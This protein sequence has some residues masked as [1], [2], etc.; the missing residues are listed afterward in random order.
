MQKPKKAFTLVELLVVIAIIG[1]LIALLLPAVQAAREASRRT[2]CANNL[3][4]MGLGVH[5][6]HSANNAL[7]PSVIRTY[8]IPTSDSRSWMTVFVHL[9]P[10]M[11]QLSLYEFTYATTNGFKQSLTIGQQADPSSSDQTVGWWYQLTDDEQ[12]SLGAMYAFHC[13]SRRTSGL[14]QYVET[15]RLPVPGW[16]GGSAGP[17]GD[18]AMVNATIGNGTQGTFWHGDPA[19]VDS[20]CGPFRAA[21]TSDPD[22]SDLFHTIANWKCR[23]DF[24]YWA[25]GTSNVIVFGE[26]HI[27]V[28][29]LQK[30]ERN[31]GI[32]A[33]CSIFTAAVHKCVAS[34][35]FVTGM[36]GKQGFDPNGDLSSI[37][38]PVARGPRDLGNSIDY[39]R[40][41]SYHPGIAQFLLGDGAVKPL[42]VTTAPT[43][44]GRLGMVNDRTPVSMP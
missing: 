19:Y 36:E 43:I 42:S 3:K 29:Q 24:S 44:L 23:D 5:N 11:E 12:E 41:G 21:I 25:D 10:Y 14:P 30:C 9:L 35:V 38:L 17:R 7:P 20:F 1:V 8:F 39:N 34:M 26:K 16:D 13:S 33:D 28:D 18:Y 37:A 2:Q 32:N 15:H 6:F 31:A 22:T 40:F 27:P 4:Q